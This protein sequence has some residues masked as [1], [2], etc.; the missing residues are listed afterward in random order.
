MR[1]NDTIKMPVPEKPGQMPGAK[2]EEEQVQQGIS[3]ARLRIRVGVPAVSWSH[4]KW[5]AL[6]DQAL[7]E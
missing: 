2:A 1:H 7:L 4:A 6:A 5:L 3:P